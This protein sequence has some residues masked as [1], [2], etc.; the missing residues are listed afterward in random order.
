MIS[1]RFI[2]MH[3]KNV[4]PKTLGINITLLQVIN[5]ECLKGQEV[6]YSQTNSRIES[7]QIE[8]TRKTV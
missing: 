7:Y 3:G 6:F 5:G 2:Q 1:D 4:N 8:W